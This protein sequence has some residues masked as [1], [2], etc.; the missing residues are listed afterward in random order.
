M[1]AQRHEFYR[2]QADLLATDIARL[3]KRNTLFVAG[4]LASFL[5]AVAAVAAY[6][7]TST[8]YTFIYTAMAMLVLYLAIRQRDTAN[9]LRI[10]ELTNRHDVYR[11]EAAYQEGLFDA[12]DDG[13]RYADPHHPYTT[14]MDVFGRKSLFQRI[15]RTVTTGGSD[16]LARELA[17]WPCGQLA[18]RADAIDE[19]A[20]EEPLRT[21]FLAH[22]QRSVIHTAE[23]LRALQAI[24]E[25]RL[26]TYPKSLAS[27]LV[28]CTSITGL[29]LS[30]ALAV[31]GLLPA[32]VPILWGTTQ[33]AA[34][35]IANARTL[36]TAHKAVDS[37]HRQMQTYIR[38]IMLI[39]TS[40]LQ[41]R[42][43]RDIINRLAG[44][45]SHDALRSFGEL[46]AI[47][48]RLD[49][50]GNQLGLFL[51][52]AFACSDYFLVRRFLHWQERYRLAGEEWIAA[53][54]HFDA[55]VSMATFRYNEPGAVR[56]EWIEADGVV[57]D[58]RGL[59]HPFLG[60][61][62]IPNDIGLTDRHYYLI[63]GAN[64]AGKSTF[65]RTIGINYI[66][67]R[68][69]LPVFAERLRVSVFNL[70]SSMR[71][72]D[73]LVEGISYFN[74]ELLRLKQL[75][76]YCRHNRHTLV[77]LDEILKGT[78]S[79]DK[80]NGS[81]LFLEHASH[82][83]VTGIVATHDLE[84]SKMADAQ[85]DRFHNYCFEISL[86]DEVTYTYKITE[87]VARNQNATFLLRKFVL[88]EKS[89]A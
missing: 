48:D 45:E 58:A 8:G 24:R 22:G 11:K 69:G 82:L 74:A 53:V 33:F 76:A 44:E 10:E 35:F 85:P 1:N 19:L 40:G 42:E 84:L 31:G 36:R 77:I 43:S 38:L 49:R 62:A 59:R 70:F 39:A 2:K 63:T 12:F 27:L 51:S 81:R 37:I 79:L 57:Y 32:E 67:A 30:M 72:T 56:A 15:N 89:D 60:G 7:S 80:L 5:L 50:R 73:D 16:L 25:L 41:S 88:R 21:S 66:L 6:V 46:Q 54:S 17:D 68:C 34:V 65:L 3:R 61:D 83:P 18:D 71:T 87:G 13:A 28:V 9:S 14:D 64:M 23:V 26:P 55:L 29:L 78:N 52:N 86:T 4:E 47:L 75:T 20:E